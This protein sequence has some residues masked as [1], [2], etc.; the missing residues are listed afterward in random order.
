VPELLNIIDS[1]CFERGG[2]L[3]L[4]YFRLDYLITCYLY[5]VI[6]IK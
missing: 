3:T 6:L 4:D 1:S 2:D 5:Y